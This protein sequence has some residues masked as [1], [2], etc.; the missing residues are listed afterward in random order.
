V[1]TH[2]LAE[3]GEMREEIVLN[4]PHLPHLPYLYKLKK[5]NRL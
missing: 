5:T 2:Q 3:I 1:V 4:L